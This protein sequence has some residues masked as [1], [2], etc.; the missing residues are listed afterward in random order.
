MADQLSEIDLARKLIETFHLSVDERAAIPGDAIGIR[1]LISIV[2]DS[3][4]DSGWFPR[5]GTPD[6]NGDGAAIEAQKFGYR[7]YRR[8]EIG[9]MRYG[10]VTTKRVL[11]LQ[12]AVRIY[13]E[14]YSFSYDIDGVPIAWTR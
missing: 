12:K 5:G 1:A 10:P 4:S 11:S 2:Q 6:I 9:V 3:L 8:H 14:H 13:L 7:I